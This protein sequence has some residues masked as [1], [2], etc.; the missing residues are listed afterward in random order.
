MPS[1][2]KVLFPSKFEELSLRTVEELYPLRRAGLE[3]VVL[4]AVIDRDEVGF[5]PYGGFD[6]DLAEQLREEARL[7]F[8][9]WAAAL[10]KEGLRAKT[11]VEIGRP[12]SQILEVADR[13]RVDL[14][15]AGRQR[16]LHA[17]AVHVGATTLEILRRARVPVL[18]A[19][20]PADDPLP[21]P[22]NVFEHA[23]YA[24]D[25]SAASARALDEILALAGAVRRVSAVHVLSDRDFRHRSPHEVEAEERAARAELEE[26]CGRLRAAGIE[27][28]AHVRA[29][30]AVREILGAAED[31]ACTCLVLGTTGRE[32]LAEFFLGS[33]SHRVAEISHLPSLLVPAPAAHD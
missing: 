16:P 11:L 5:I 25:F 3:E 1:V 20:P 9:D 23:L 26:L 24:T 21:R 19:R 6:R 29:G 22:A 8:A 10:E 31:E 7:R 15:V 12:A 27:A 33:V 13:E 2:R 32:A 28:N 4:L 18:V 17:G 14:V 30:H